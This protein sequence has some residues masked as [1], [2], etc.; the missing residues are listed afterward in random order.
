MIADPEERASTRDNFSEATKARLAAEVGY[1]CSL[2]DS[3]APTIG[4]SETEPKGF[5]NSGIAAHIT[6]AASNGPQV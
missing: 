4:P 5:S 2:P 6:A 1:R 3:G